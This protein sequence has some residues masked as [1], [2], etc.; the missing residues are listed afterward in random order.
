[1]DVPNHLIALV[2][3]VGDFLQSRIPATDAAA[4]HNG[5]ATTMRRR[6]TLSVFFLVSIIF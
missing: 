4:L 6:K 2:F 5:G 3:I 1:M